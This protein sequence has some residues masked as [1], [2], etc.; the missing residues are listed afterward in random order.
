MTL[1]ASP[2]FQYG[3]NSSVV[4]AVGNN[5]SIE[6]QNT[7]TTIASL[8]RTQEIRPF[9]FS[10]DP[11]NNARQEINL[12]KQVQ[13]VTQSFYSLVRNTPV[14]S[15]FSEA[16]RQTIQ[17]TTER[18]LS[19]ISGE[20]LALETQVRATQTAQ[21][22]LGLGLVQTQNA[23][24]NAESQLSLAQANSGQQVQM[25]RNQ[26]LSAKN[27]QNELSLKAPFDGI[28]TQRLVD[29]GALIAP[30][31]PLFQLA[32]RSILKIYTD[33]PDTHIG[34]ISEGMSVQIKVDGLSEL[35]SGKI[36]RLD[37]AVNPQTR[38]LGVEITLDTAPEQIR[39]G[40]FARISVELREKT[41]FFVPKRFIQ[42]TFDGTF[43]STKKG[44]SIAVELGEEKN[45]KREI[46]SE[47]LQDGMILQSK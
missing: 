36:S 27:M 21:E 42:S 34:N 43:V 32:D 13:N 20:I 10:H 15:S 3:S 31:S 39:I 9:P 5:N 4:V 35:F 45:E 37:P 38:T 29:E 2:Q 47:E 46:I 7:K 44:K 12:L 28:I 16:K 11:L 30:G 1:G 41:T 23:I 17:Q 24:K 18:Y 25:A 14:T 33:I 6:K 8:V 19:E 26:I 40:M 22:Q